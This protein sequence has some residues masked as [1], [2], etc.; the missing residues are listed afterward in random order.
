M[1]VRNRQYIH[2]LYSNG[3]H[4]LLSHLQMS[5]PMSLFQWI[6]TQ[7]KIQKEIEYVNSHILRK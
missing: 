7:S 4:D 2:G 1:C 5:I 6:M 3:T